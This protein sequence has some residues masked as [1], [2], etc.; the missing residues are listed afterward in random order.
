MTWPPISG[1]P[2]EYE[3]SVVPKRYRTCQIPPVIQRLVQSGG[4]FW[5]GEPADEGADERAARGQP[6]SDLAAPS[7]AAPNGQGRGDVSKGRLPP[8]GLYL[9]DERQRNIV[10]P[11]SEVLNPATLLLL[12]RVAGEP[13]RASVA[14]SIFAIRAIQPCLQGNSTQVIFVVERSNTTR[15]ASFRI[16]T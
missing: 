10:L 15:R 8:P 2:T 7:S 5:Q 9:Q 3:T 16:L 4:S 13:L 11:R 1:M 6:V 14:P 12:E